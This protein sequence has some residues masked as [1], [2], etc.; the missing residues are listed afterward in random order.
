MPQTYKRYVLLA[1]LVFMP[2]MV[3]SA[4]EKT[5][6]AKVEA[7]D[8][9]KSSITLD[10]LTLDVTRKTKINVDGKQVDLSNL[11]TGQTVR[12]I[13]EDSLDAAISIKLVDLE[14]DEQATAKVMKALQG[15]WLCIAAEELG[16][17]L[18]KRS[19]RDQNRVLSIKGQTITMDRTIYNERKSY[20]GKF[21]ID[22]ENGTFDF[23][24]AENGALKQWM[25][26]Y[27]LDGDILKLCYRYKSG[28]DNARPKEFKSDKNPKPLTLFHTFKREREDDN[29][30]SKSMAEK[31][32]GVY[33]VI[34]TEPNGKQGVLEYEFLPS[35]IVLRAGSR[36][37]KWEIRQGQIVITFLEEARGSVIITPQNEN[38]IVGKHTLGNGMT[39]IWTG[40]KK[41][42]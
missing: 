33:E 42:R 25:G 30:S 17:K 20:S 38:R 21:E 19:V 34:W 27:E 15:E 4:A 7:V 2:P 32:V 5:I 41:T 39:S 14:Y 13:Y 26:I 9:A 3:A 16:A 11:K 36:A 35:K 24:G 12:V 10:G 28:D 40:K 31:F 22:P 18:D 29:S 8:K 1:A 23:I 6:Q 37:G